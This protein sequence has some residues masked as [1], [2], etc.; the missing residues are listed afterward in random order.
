MGNRIDTT[1][2]RKSEAA[3]AQVIESAQRISESYGDYLSDESRYGPSSADRLVLVRDE[4]QVAEELAASAEAGRETTVSAGRTGIVG[5]AVPTRGTLLSLER[6]DRIR[7]V[8]R[9][10]DGRFCVRVEPGVSVSDLRR[11]LE[12]GDLGVDD[13]RMDEGEREALAALR[14]DG[15]RFFYPP[16]PT[17]DTAHIGATVAT[18]A[19]G[20]RSYRYGATR[21]HVHGV[22]LCLT[23][24]EILAMSRGDCMAEGRRFVICEGGVDRVV[25]AP[26]YNMPATKNAAGYYSEDGMDLIDLI[27][28]SEGTLGVIT[29]VELVL[30]PAPEGVLSALAFFASDEDAIAFVRRARGDSS[31]FRGA[32]GVDPIALEF[33]DSRSLDFLRER[34]IQEGSSSDIPELP[35]SAGA[36]VLFE[37]DYTEETLETSYE[38]WEEVLLAHG[39]SME[40]TW[41]G[42][43]ESEL[44]RLRLLRHSI[45]EE[46]NGAIAR[47]KALHS[48]I[49]KIGTDASVPD[50]ALEIMFGF[51]RSELDV[52]NLAH[53]VFGHIGDNHLHLN[54]MPRTPE[55]LQQG[56]ELAKRFAARAVELGGSVS[57][58]HGIGKIKHEFLR[59]QYGDEGLR[60]M[61]AVKR[62]FDPP[63]ILNRGVIFPEA[64]LAR[65]LHFGGSSER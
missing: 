29:E 11:R 43:E 60:Q 64:L 35:E 4:A 40:D 6:M 56:K 54:I 20:A 34:K 38:A 62:A 48:G 61:A 9:L 50:D 18:N 45:A 12:S 17:E 36:A 52:T 14:A 27:V 10:P 23:S 7:G 42:L 1:A 44:E 26:N 33:F 57:A 51:Y 32:D 49:H 37:Q 63:C 46:V 15:R 24:G 65:G 47:A 16:D 41:G 21:R 5:G 25:D 53:V 28:G 59:L 3:P 13:V 19:S 39:S 58:E 55:E 31:A 2:P 8:V 30:S 22:R